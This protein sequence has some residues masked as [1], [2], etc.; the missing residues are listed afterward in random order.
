M[1]S[2]RRYP[3]MILL[4]L[5]VAATSLLAG[6]TDKKAALT[7]V[8]SITVEQQAIEIEGHKESVTIMPDGLV[9]KEL[10]VGDDVTADK[11]TAGPEVFTKLVKLL[12][13]NRFTELAD[14]V[15]TQSKDGAVL[16]I[17]VETEDGVYQKGGLNPSDQAFMNCYNGCMELL[18]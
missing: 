9:R 6:C 1:K 15:S 17:I 12:E 10:S 3:G 11:S 18:Q 5:A 2:K 7:G 13:E 8:K 16:T 14:D 4:L